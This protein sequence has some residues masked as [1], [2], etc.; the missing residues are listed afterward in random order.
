MSGEQ[1]LN[2]DEVDALLKGVNSGTVATGTG[3]A[4]GESQCYDFSN[5]MRIVRGRLP[6][7]EM[8]NERFARLFRTSI[9]SLLR[10]SPDIHRAGG[11]D[12]RGGGRARGDRRVAGSVG[13][14]A[15]CRRCRTG[16]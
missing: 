6:T 16:R 12:G 11:G 7:L 1:V 4:T 8:I 5:E 3:A 15:R 10:R 2:Q 13:R 9:Y 14:A